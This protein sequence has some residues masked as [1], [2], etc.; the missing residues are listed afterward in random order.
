MQGGIWQCRG[1]DNPRDL[2]ILLQGNHQEPGLSMVLAAAYF[3]GFWGY[4]WDK[5]PC[6]CCLTVGGHDVLQ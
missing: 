4:K 3:M 6:P 2:Q 5:P 1:A